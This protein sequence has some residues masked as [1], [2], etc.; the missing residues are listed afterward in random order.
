MVKI[1]MRRVVYL[2]VV[3][4]LAVGL[5]GCQSFR[6]AAGLNKQAPDEFAVVSKAPLI[7]PPDYN[8]RPPKPG[9]APTNQVSPTDAAEG[10]LY[11]AAPPATSSRG[12]LSLGEQ[13]LLDKAG[14]SDANNLI[15]QRI[16]A[17]N[18]AMFAA[19]NSF[20]E[21]LLFQS[22]TSDASAGTPLKTS[23][24]SPAAPAQQTSKTS[25]QP[26]P[27]RSSNGSGTIQDA[28]GSWLGGIF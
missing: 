19:D 20:T 9:E 8:L 1:E 3:A 12:Q 26:G 11:G 13:A 21:R 28:I 18:H 7:I 14:A 27:E 25:A 4:G 5:S 2:A 24:A 23:G 16:A 15:R 10:T 22:G 6:D 17:D